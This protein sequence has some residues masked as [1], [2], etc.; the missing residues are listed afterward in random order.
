MKKAQIDGIGTRVYIS[1]MVFIYKQVTMW[2]GYIVELHKYRHWRKN[3]I[4][5]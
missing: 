4:V 2:E 3:W 5:R 1:I